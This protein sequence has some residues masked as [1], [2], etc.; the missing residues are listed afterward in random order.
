MLGAFALPGARQQHKHK[1]G[2]RHQRA[3]RGN[4]RIDLIP[5]RREHSLG[6]RNDLEKIDRL[7][8]KLGLLPASY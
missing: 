2:G 1:G 8:P 6:Q 4:A 7:Y 3:D 5:Q